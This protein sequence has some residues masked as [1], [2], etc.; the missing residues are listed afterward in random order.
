VQDATYEQLKTLLDNVDEI[1]PRNLDMWIKWAH[2]EANL[3]NDL[4][5]SLQEAIKGI[6]MSPWSVIKTRH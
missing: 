1:S 5:Y 3:F 6:L 4:D 2:G